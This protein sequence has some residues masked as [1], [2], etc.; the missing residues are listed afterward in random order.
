MLRRNKPLSEARGGMKWL[1]TFAVVGA[2]LVEGSKFP[3]AGYAYI[4]PGGQ[5]AP[6]NPPTLKELPT[7]DAVVKWEL[8]HGDISYGGGYGDLNRNI[9]SIG[10]M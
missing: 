10:Y 8:S 3:S 6:T 1:A 2:F 4:I 7:G 9:T 5:V